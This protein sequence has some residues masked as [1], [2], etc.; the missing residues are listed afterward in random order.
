MPADSPS[1]LALRPVREMTIGVA[2]LIVAFAWPLYQWAGFALGSELYSHVLLIPLVSAY[3]LHEGREKIFRD[4][5]RDP[6]WGAALAV[7]GLA[8]I[9]LWLLLPRMGVALPVEDRIALSTAAFLLLLLA[10]WVTLLG[11]AAARAAAFPLGFLI[12]MVPFP[13]FA[14][15]GIEVFLQ[16]TSASAAFAMFQAA[17]TTVFRQDLTFVLPGITLEVAPQCSGIRSSLVLFITSVL[18]G[19]LFLR[20][21]WKKAFLAAAVIPLA[22]VRNGFRVF[23]LGELCI[24]VSPDMIH[25][26]IHKRGGPVFFVLSLIPFF[27]LLW[28][29]YRTDKRKEGGKGIRG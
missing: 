5:S 16:H 3:L 13:T 7:L 14:V 10:L 12:F 4:F 28:F 9:G 18:A 22:F 21:R 15:E 17:G 1:L 24:R 6:A 23:V 29:L 11:R 27:I 2:V 26:W 8:A 19:H 25:S 20:T